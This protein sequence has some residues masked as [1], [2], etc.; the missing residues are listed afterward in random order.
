[1]LPLPIKERDKCYDVLSLL[2]CGVESR[3]ATVRLLPWWL[4]QALQPQI[5]PPPP[6]D[7]SRKQAHQLAQMQIVSSSGRSRK[8]WGAPSLLAS[9]WPG[10]AEAAELA[11]C[12]LVCAQH[13][14]RTRGRVWRLVHHQGEDKQPPPPAHH[15]SS[16]LPP[17]ANMMAAALAIGVR[18][19][20]AL[21]AGR[22]SSQAWFCTASVTRVS[23]LPH[24][25]NLATH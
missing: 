10:R 14:P 7:W 11:A 5:L 2:Q 1:M 24:L 13:F 19:S 17:S 3:P 25:P 22:P 6:R 20:I 15:C 4:V 18:R 23:C 8:G 16:S 9:Q 21:P 12:S